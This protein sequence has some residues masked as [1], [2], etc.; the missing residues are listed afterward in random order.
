MATKIDWGGWA[1][2]AFA[3]GMNILNNAIAGKSTQGGKLYYSTTPNP[4]PVSGGGFLSKIS[5]PMIL[6]LGVAA[7]AVLLILKKKR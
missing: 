4:N 7:G 5:T 1:N 6:A 2:Q 3:T